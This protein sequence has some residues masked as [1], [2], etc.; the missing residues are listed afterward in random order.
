MKSP[1]AL[2]GAAVVWL[3]L[4]ASC[5]TF[6]NSNS[7][8]QNSP[9]AP[10]Q[11]LSETELR[12]DIENRIARLG[13]LEGVRSSLESDGFTITATENGDLW[14]TK[15]IRGPFPTDMVYDV[16]VR[17]TDAGLKIVRVKTWGTGP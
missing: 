17:Q 7:L 1:R 13:S 11:L 16:V 10:N 15:K 4:A 14:A 3:V 8:Q 6:S 2:I 12:L 9:I 5:S